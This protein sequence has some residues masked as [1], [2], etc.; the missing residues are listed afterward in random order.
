M[1]RKLILFLMFSCLISCFIFFILNSDFSGDA[2]KTNDYY[3]K[4]KLKFSGRILETIPL[5]KGMGITFLKVSSSNLKNHDLRCCSR[6]YLMLIQ[7]SLA[8][9]YLLEHVFDKG[10]SLVI[11]YTS[12]KLKCYGA[13]GKLE[14]ETA[15]PEQM[16]T[17]F[18]WSQI[19]KN[20]KLK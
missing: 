15:L 3:N 6:D 19:M 14:I 17:S 7:D 13:N 20:S 10:D 16:T 11:D 18:Y 9:L 1:N 5:E 8:E 12:R 2:N 4:Y